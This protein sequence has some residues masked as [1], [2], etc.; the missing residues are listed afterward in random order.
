MGCAVGFS[1]DIKTPAWSVPLLKSVRYKGAKGGRGSGKSHFFAELLVEAMVIDK[2]LSAVCIREIQKSLKFSAKKLVEGKIRSMGVSHLFEIQTNEIKRIGGTGVCIFQGLQDHTADS[3]KSLEGFK[4]CWVEEA[5]SLSAR[6]MELLLPTIRTPGSQIWFSWNPDQPDDPVQKMFD[7]A[8]AAN[9]PDFAVV[10]VNFMQNPFCP[11]ETRKEAKR[12]LKYNP[13]TY[14]HV[15]LG[16]FN[17]KND[18]KIF[19]GK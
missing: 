18:A 4:I 14:E 3:I 1:L 2:D 5:N 9:D 15:Y 7:D 11:E 17:V 12:H 13:D 6:S 16:G 8:E 19:N 10:H